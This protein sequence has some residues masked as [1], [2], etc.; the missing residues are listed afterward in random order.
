MV[1]QIMV[2]PAQS[3]EDFSQHFLNKM[4]G[5]RNSKRLKRQWGY[6]LSAGSCDAS[7]GGKKAHVEAV[8]WMATESPFTI[9]I[10]WIPDLRAFT[11]RVSQILDL[12]EYPTLSERDERG[13][14]LKTYLSSQSRLE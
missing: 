5:E 9:R 2:S 1:M 6:P 3:H 12:R 13:S 10:P 11:I 4:K 8:H 7:F 14:T